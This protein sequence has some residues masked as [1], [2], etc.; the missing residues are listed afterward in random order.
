[1]LEQNVLY[2]LCF[3]HDLLMSLRIYYQS[4]L[5]KPVAEGEGAAP[6]IKK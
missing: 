4:L 1:M 6:P 2:P 3:N 5:P